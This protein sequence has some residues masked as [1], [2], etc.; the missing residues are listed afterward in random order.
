M[1]TFSSTFLKAFKKISLLVVVILLVI[2]SA[3][4][5]AEAE[6]IARTCIDVYVQDGKIVIDGK[7]SGRTTNPKPTTSSTARP[8]PQPKPKST[9]TATTKSTYRPRI[10]KPKARTSSP[11][12]ADKVLQSLPTLQVAYQPEGAALT[13]VPV[14]FFT[15]LP[16]FFNKD[17][18]ILGIKVRINVRPRSV[19]SF[20][21]GFTL[22]TSKPGRPYPAT[23]ITHSYSMPGT[24]LV[25]VATIWDGSYSIA[26]N[27][28]AIPGVIRQNSAIEVKVVGAGTKFVGK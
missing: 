25:T 5:V 13:K 3:T 21:D 4:Q 27:T 15:D 20:G 6:C 18:N 22:I 19:W 8:K 28:R 14:V 7:R 11:S 16:T 24:Y 17:F 9:S 2:S 26:G 10:T 12:L 23:D 1:F